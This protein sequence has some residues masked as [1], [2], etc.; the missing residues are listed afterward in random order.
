M[1]ALTGQSLS[2][3]LSLSVTLTYSNTQMQASWRYI[4][5]QASLYHSCHFMCVDPVSEVD[6]SLV[7]RSSSQTT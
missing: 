2:L 3:A 1:R 6:I 4:N 7:K 5:K